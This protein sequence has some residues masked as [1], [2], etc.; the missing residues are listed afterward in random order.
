MWIFFT[1]LVVAL[2]FSLIA[3]HWGERD[4]FGLS[5]LWFFLIFLFP[6]WTFSIWVP[7][8]G[9]VHYGVPFFDIFLL[10][11]FLMLI[12]LA[13]TPTDYYTYRKKAVEASDKIE[14]KR[15][16][17]AMNGFFWA[18]LLFILVLLIVGL[19]FRET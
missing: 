12:I 8:V 2:I 9:P 17:R 3:S 5:M 18:F 14:M 16:S 1:V 7:P 13:A 10:A 15:W 4:L 19:L 6:L 11:L